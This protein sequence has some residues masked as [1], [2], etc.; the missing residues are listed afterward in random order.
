M[1]SCN[2]KTSGDWCSSFLNDPYN[3]VPIKSPE[4]RFETSSLINVPRTRGH[5]QDIGGS[6][7]LREVKR[8]TPATNT[9]NQNVEATTIKQQNIHFLLQDPSFIK[10][11]LFD[12]HTSAT[13]ATGEWL[14]FN[15]IHF[16]FEEVLCWKPQ[17]GKI[18]NVMKPKQKQVLCYQLNVHYSSLFY[19]LWLVG[20]LLRSVSWTIFWHEQRMSLSYC[21]G[22]RFRVYLDPSLL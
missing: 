1:V 21:R 17:K 14:H 5:S 22:P 20:L 18:L 2:L 19:G 10:S 7:A 13:A 3:W 6:G 16:Y 4:S 9:K 11:H 15:R 8:K 12:R